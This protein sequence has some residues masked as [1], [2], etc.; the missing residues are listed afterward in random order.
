LPT[1]AGY[2]VVGLEENTYL[3]VL[4]PLLPQPEFIHTFGA[5]VEVALGA[6]GLPAGVAQGE[7]QAIVKEAAFAKNDNRSLLGSVNDVAFHVSV[8]LEDERRIT[9]ATLRRIQ[10][11]LN[12]MPH[13][14]REPPFPDQAVRFLLGEA[15]VI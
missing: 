2:L 13:V 8:A 5:A 11:Q 6:L 7:A 9:V 14:N 12:Q 4:C 1:R 15:H 10:L 3:T